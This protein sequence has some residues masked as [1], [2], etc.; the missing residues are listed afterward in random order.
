M[1]N[2][3]GVIAPMLQYTI[4]KFKLYV[5]AWPDVQRPLH[6]DLHSPHYSCK[7]KLNF[8]LVT[9]RNMFEA[10]FVALPYI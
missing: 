10:F 2:K 7:P 9:M 4:S 6:L 3:L 1:R 5:C 8:N